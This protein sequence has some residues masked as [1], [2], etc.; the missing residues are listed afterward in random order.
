M[1]RNTCKLTQRDP[2]NPLEKYWSRIFPFND[3][4]LFLNALVTEFIYTFIYIED[5]LE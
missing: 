5:K 1:T 2:W 3:S 4:E